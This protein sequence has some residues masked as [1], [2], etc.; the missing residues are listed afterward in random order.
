MD[1]DITQ[2]LTDGSDGG[3]GDVQPSH[4]VDAQPS[5]NQ[6]NDAEPVH[7]QDND[8]VPVNQRSIRDTL[9]NAFK[10]EGEEKPEG[11]GEQKPKVVVPELTQDGE[12]RWRTSDGLF[13][14][15][16]QIEAY[17]TSKQPE[18]PQQQVDQYA[19]F[20]SQL[21]AE[22][23]KA[24]KAL[25]AEIQQVVGRTMEAVYGQ[26]GRYSEYDQLEQ[27]LIG[28]RRDAWAAQGMNPAVAINQLFALS[29]FAGRDP[30]S[31]VLW[32]AE[33]N[34]VDLDA[35][36]DARDAQLTA[37]PQVQALQRQVSQMGNTIQGYTTA[38]QQQMQEANAAAV[39][40]FTQET[41]GA[42]KPKRPYLAEVMDTFAHHVQVQR[43]A[44]P[45]A[46]PQEV[47]QAAYEAACWANPQVRLAMQK[48]MAEQQRQNEQQ[49]VTQKRIAGSSI[50]GGPTGQQASIQP[51]DSN[52]SLRDEL[53]AQFASAQ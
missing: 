25:P 51:Q 7:T 20:T 48:E 17:Q 35:A 42:G 47:L 9:S 33:N 21:N 28:P 38:Q 45:A 40:H 23:Q 31:F 34:G 5:N 36:L 13:A 1:I 32:F 10:G 22:E 18:N 12:G 50:A 44:K 52:L 49:R 24:F 11:E 39:Q 4:G 2:D 53:K 46:Q 3:L 29:D 41:D 15:T 8:A 43:A 27:H 30:Q 16:E 37:D 19:N 6:V 14:S 26:A